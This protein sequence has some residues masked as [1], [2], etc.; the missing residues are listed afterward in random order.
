MKLLGVKLARRSALLLIAACTIASACHT[1]RELLYVSAEQAGDVAVI[2]LQKGELIERIAVGKRPRGLRLSND[3]RWLYVALSGSPPS[4]PGVDPSSLPPAERGA[5]GIAVIDLQTHKL[6]RR[7]AG[8]RDPEAFDLSPD[9][10]TL[11]VSNEETAELGIVDVA[12]GKLL[13]RVTVGD[14]PEG[15]RV[16]PDG[17]LVYVTAER[18]DAVFAVDTRSRAVVARIATGKRPRALAFTRDGSALFVSNEMSGTITR[19]DPR[20]QSRLGSTVL[21]PADPTS[22]RPMG[23]VLAADG[24]RVFVSTGRGGSIAIL[25]AANGRLLRLVRDVGAR[26]WGID[27]DADGS[28]VFTANGPSDDISILDVASGRVLKRLKVSG[29]PWGLVFAKR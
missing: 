25:D 21:D 23:L 22:Q 17:A 6:V 3:G 28:H 24:K 10:K 9:G 12:S 4:G 5:D 19:I 18:D 11:F 14:E 15:V 16:A 29:S 1:P 8:G 27:V 26:P 20:T 7:L 2:D 13:H